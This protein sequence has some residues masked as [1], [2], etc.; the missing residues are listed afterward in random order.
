MGGRRLSL[1]QSWKW[2]DE[3]LAP[4]WNNEHSIPSLNTVNVLYCLRSYEQAGQGVVVVHYIDI[5]FLFLF[6]LLF[7]LCNHDFYIMIKHNYDNHSAQLDKECLL[8]NSTNHVNHESDP[9]PYQ[10]QSRSSR[11][12]R[13]NTKIKRDKSTIA[14]QIQVQLISILKYVG[15]L[16]NTNLQT[17]G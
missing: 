10:V 6:F 4:I 12:K 8:N 2:N 7:L 3:H 13:G 5:Y 11:T 9:K 17:F 1:S 15:M 14:R 16:V